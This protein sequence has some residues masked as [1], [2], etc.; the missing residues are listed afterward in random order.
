M[1]HNAL[2]ISMLHSSEDLKIIISPALE[3]ILSVEL[4]IRDLVTV[5]SFRYGFLY[6][7]T[8]KL[9]WGKYPVALA[10]CSNA[11]FSSFKFSF[12]VS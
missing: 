9:E 1:L 4:L 12:L 5:R 3:I 7:Y 8:I 2:A 10:S 11:N 6:F